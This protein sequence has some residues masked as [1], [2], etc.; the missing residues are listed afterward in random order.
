VISVDPV[1]LDDEL[2]RGGHYDTVARDVLAT[3]IH[4]APVADGTRI[5]LGAL[6]AALVA[7]RS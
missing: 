1:E 4:R 7:I 2:D 5:D 6:G 3:A